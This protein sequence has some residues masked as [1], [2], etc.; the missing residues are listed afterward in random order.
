MLSKTGWAVLDVAS[1]LDEDA[2]APPTEEGGAETRGVTVAVATVVVTDEPASPPL[3][4]EHP[5]V[6]IASATTEAAARRTII[7]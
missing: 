3:L 2:V 1:G 5:A 4:V 7:P 6:S